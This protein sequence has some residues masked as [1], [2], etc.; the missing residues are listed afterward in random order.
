VTCA[1]VGVVGGGVGG[2]A[3]ALALFRQGREVAVFEQ[4]RR[5]G[6]VGADVNLTPNATRALDG[7]GVGDAIRER[8]AR[9]SARLSRMWDT[10]E[11]TSRIVMG[12]DA[13]RRYGAPQLTLHRSD[14]LA[15][16]DAALPEGVVRFDRKAIRVASAEGEASIAFE[17]GGEE[18]FEAL[19]G[20]DGIHSIVREA[21]L[22]PGHPRF[23]GMVAYR[24]I[25]A[26]ETI[27]APHLDAFVKWWGPDS[28][29][30]IVVFPLNRGRE[31]FVFATKAQDDWTEE[32]WT[33][34]GNVDELRASYASFHPDA[35]RVL[36]ACR[37]VL[38]TALYER[39]PL[40]T[41]TKGA[42][43]L[44][45]D[46][47]HPMLPFMAQ[48]A[49]QALEDA[50]VLGRCVDRAG[51]S[52]AAFRAYEAARLARTTQIQLGS[53]RNDWMREGGAVDWVYGYDAWA[54]PIEEPNMAPGA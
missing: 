37:D 7:L 10:G 30:Q 41:W 26:R 54:A 45:G 17:D 21:I 33:L 14:L 38:K 12:D 24:A 15:A 18:R 4:A 29:S 44:L 32:S 20:A 23:T 2:L 1:P 5:F 22:G 3:L 35:R 28:N 50:V 6:R 51:P 53:R 34:P 47:C 40:T 9:P 42:L 43:V 31:I 39:D 49:G 13:A 27:D 52:P 48:G 25:V 19:I 8:S 11:I 16:L 36:D 46:A